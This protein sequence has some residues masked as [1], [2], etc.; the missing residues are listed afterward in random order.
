MIKSINESFKFSNK[1]LVLATPLI[2]F[3]LFSGIYLVFSLHG[4]TL[5]MFFAVILFFMMLA[6]FASG[7]LYMIMIALKDDSRE[8]PNS[9]IK[10]FPSGVGEYFLPVLGMVFN[11]IIVSGLVLFAGYLIG[12]KFIGDPGIAPQAFSKAMESAV[13]LKQFLLSLTKEQFIRLNLWNMLLLASV[14]FSYFIMMFYPPAIMFKS[15]NPF[16]A[17]FIALKDLFNRKFLKNLSLYIFIFSLYAV[18]SILSAMLGNN[19]ILHFIMTLVNFYY[20]MFTAV[21]ILN[22]YYSNYIKIGSNI[23]TTV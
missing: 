3:S 7:W 20:M 1:Y 14:S 15:K 8:D 18:I 22:Y 23:D 11:G 9:L 4:N 16:K 13:N 2:L 21:L 6:A 19:I 5:S 10:E 12:I 17:F